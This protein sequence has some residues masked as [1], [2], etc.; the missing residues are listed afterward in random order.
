MSA[1]KE[2]KTRQEQT[3]SGWVD[4]KTAREAQQ[5]KEEKRNNILY[6]AIAILFVVVAAATFVW[7]SGIVQRTVTAATVNGEKY[8]AGEVQYYYTTTYQNFLNSEY[9]YYASMLGLDIT[10]SLKDQE[11]S[12]D[13]ESDTWYDFFLNQGLQQ[14]A[15][16]HAICEKAEADGFTW[17]DEMQASF[18]ESMQSLQESVDTYNGA[19]ATSLKTEDYL[20]QVYGSTMTQDIYEEQLKLT[21]QAQIYSNSFVN[22]L[23]YSDSE[24]EAAYSEDKNGYDLVNYECVRINGAAE[25][26][27]DADGNT[28]AATDDEKAAAMQAAQDLADSM[29]ASYQDGESLEDLAA[30]EDK[31]SYTNGTNTAYSDSVLLNWLFDSSRKDGDAAVLADESSSAYYVAV[32]GERFRPEFDVQDVRHILISP[33]DGELSSGDEGYEEEQAQLMADAKAK[34][35]ALLAQYLAGDATEEAFAALAVEN[36]ADTGSAA[37][38][39]LISQVSEISSYVENFLNWCLED[40][41]PGDTGIV[42]SVYGY[43]IMYFVGNEEAYWKAKVSSDLTSNAYTEWY[44]EATK[45][46]SYEQ[47]SG[48]RYVG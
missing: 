7:K 2:K 29:L 25:S 40:H 21:I 41:N 45:D 42:E 23:E 13:E 48:C 28:V 4:P 6:A 8:T 14:M 24:L 1:S 31:A 34:A 11:C 9:G 37:N 30:G 47:G 15:N 19:Y 20:K 32:F 44:T 5:R 26:T 46:A 35:E 22:S 39:G 33:E 43:H 17:N 12:I 16:I 3:A 27:T 18:D 36:S 38:G 10:S